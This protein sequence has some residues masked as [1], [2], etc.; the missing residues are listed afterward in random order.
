MCTKANVWSCVEANTLY[1]ERGV[2]NVTQV[3]WWHVRVLLPQK[4]LEFRWATWLVCASPWSSL[5]RLS[6]MCSPG[7]SWDPP[8]YNNCHKEECGTSVTVIFLSGHQYHIYHVRWWSQ[9]KV[10]T[11]CESVLLSTRGTDSTYTVM[12]WCPFKQCSRGCH[13]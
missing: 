3:L 13:S 2:L 9:P 10:G 7:I 5:H 12:P 6:V 8:Y 11:T 1:I 4:S